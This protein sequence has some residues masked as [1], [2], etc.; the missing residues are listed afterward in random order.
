MRFRSAY[1][2]AA[3]KDGRRVSWMIQT[4]GRPTGPIGVTGISNNLGC[5]PKDVTGAGSRRTTVNVATENRRFADNPYA[6]IQ[7]CVTTK[8]HTGDR[9]WLQLLGDI[10]LG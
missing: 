10:I 9:V 5:L 6:S 8:M 1:A 4:A 7:Q 3:G 2:A